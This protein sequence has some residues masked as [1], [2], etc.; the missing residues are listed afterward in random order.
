MK[1]GKK[2]A[3]LIGQSDEEYQS[4]FIGGFLPVVHSYGY[5]VAMFSMLY[6]YQD[7]FEQE[8]GDFSIFKLIPYKDI[9]GIVVLCDSIQTSGGIGKLMKDL[10]ENYAGPVLCI[11]G[12]YDYPTQASKSNR[13]IHALLEHLVNE[14]GYT[15]I[16]FLNG[17][18]EHPF[19]KER[20]WDY[21]TGLKELGIEYDEKRVFFGDF[22]YS[23]GVNMV[24]NLLRS[25]DKLP[26]AILCANDCMAIGVCKA[27]TGKGFKVPD[28]IAVVSY[29]STDEGRR[30]PVP[31]TSAY[32]QADHTGRLAGKNINRLIYGRNVSQEEPAPKLFIGE[33]CGCRNEGAHLVDVRRKMWDYS[34]SSISMR[35]FWAFSKASGLPTYANCIS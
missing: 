23:S 24:E 31:V 19:S 16:A 25:G 28:D 12:N 26:Q 29:D 27:L 6:K 1:N 32:I 18:R 11:D 33:S 34:S 8:Q 21:M 13:S 10:K 5:D 35:F 9:D 30:S 14:H 2:I 7:T 20:F 4:E 17:R 22:W 15:D 3:L